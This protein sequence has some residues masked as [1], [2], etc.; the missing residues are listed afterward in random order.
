ME[1]ERD[2]GVAVVEVGDGVVGEPEE[3]GGAGG[4]GEGEAPL[5][6]REE[7]A[8]RG[9]GVERVDAGDVAA[10]ELADAAPLFA[11]G[12]LEEPEAARGDE[13]EGVGL[14]GLEKVGCEGADPRG[15]SAG[16]GPR[17][18]RAW[19]LLEV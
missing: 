6:A 11:V 19:A 13:V 16:V 2:G 12:V 10:G 1:V 5:R 8:G 15:S 4:R 18:A 17:I 7:V 14:V 3:D 9:D